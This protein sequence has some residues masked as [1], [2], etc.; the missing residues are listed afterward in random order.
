[1]DQRQ[2]WPRGWA[3]AACAAECWMIV[4][5]AFLVAKILI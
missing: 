5:W 3:I 1:M 4:G 2:D